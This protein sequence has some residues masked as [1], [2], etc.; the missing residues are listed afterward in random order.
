MEKM[1]VIIIGAGA[2]GLMCA[3]EAGKRNRRV[4]VLDHAERPGKKI[5]MSGGGRCNFTNIDLNHANYMTLFH[6]P[7]C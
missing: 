2:S 6:A 1:D 4:L 7:V 5:L 3:I